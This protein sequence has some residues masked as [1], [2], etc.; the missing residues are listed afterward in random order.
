MD[1]FRQ[2]RY[3]TIEEQNSSPNYHKIA[4]WKPPTPAEL[5]LKT[6]GSNVKAPATPPTSSNRPASRIASPPQSS[7]GP[8]YP[9]TPAADLNAA[10]DQ[11]QRFLNLSY[12]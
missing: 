4:S 7:P 10:R 2:L 3:Y 9:Q 5:A 11:I 6:V 1:G 12:R 8:R